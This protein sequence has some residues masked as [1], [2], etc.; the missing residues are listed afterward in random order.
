MPIKLSIN[1]PEPIRRQALVTLHPI[2]SY[3]QAASP[4]ATKYIAISYKLELTPT[5]TTP[6]T[7]VI[8]L[9]EPVVVDTLGS[10]TVDAEIIPGDQDVGV[11]IEG[12]IIVGEGDVGVGERG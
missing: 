9:I 6:I 4:I 5:P 3:Q 11:G 7:T 1:K 2:P 12:E 8:T 10:V